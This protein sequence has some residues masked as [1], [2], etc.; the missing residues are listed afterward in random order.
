MRPLLQLHVD[1]LPASGAPKRETSHDRPDQ[2]V[3]GDSGLIRSAGR[4]PP[5]VRTTNVYVQTA[6]LT[7]LLVTII[8]MG[9]LRMWVPVVS[10]TCFLAYSSLHV[11]S[12]HSWSVGRLVSKAQALAIFG[13][14]STCLVLVV[15]ATSDELRQRLYLI[16]LAAQPIFWLF[17]VRTIRREGWSHR[18]EDDG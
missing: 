1:M 6:L 17:L 15:A 14:L 2:V 8:W 4:S 11:A 13:V 9:F 18:H 12:T 16:L 5:H 10:G 7:C 3:S